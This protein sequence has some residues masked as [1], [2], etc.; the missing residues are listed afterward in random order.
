MAVREYVQEL[1]LRL[2]KAQA[3]LDAMTA[4]DGMVF[5]FLEYLE[6]NPAWDA[7]PAT[8]VADLV[9]AWEAYKA[10]NAGNVEIARGLSEALGLEGA[11]PAEAVG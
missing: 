7:V 9:A 2:E 1:Q 3:D 10:A 5:G 11:N 4:L 6:G 8:T